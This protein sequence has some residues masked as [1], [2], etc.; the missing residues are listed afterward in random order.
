MAQAAIRADL[1]ES[2][3]VE[4]DLAAQVALD[5]VAPIDDLAQPVD[6]VLGQIA[7]ALAYG[8]WRNQRQAADLRDRIEVFNTEAEARSLPTA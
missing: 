3:D 5:L 6:L 2:L 1:L 8:P 7:Q 4:R